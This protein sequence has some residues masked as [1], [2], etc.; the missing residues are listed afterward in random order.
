MDKPS[1]WMYPTFRRLG[2]S[3][4][5]AAA[6]MGMGA[7]LSGDASASTVEISQTVSGSVFGSGNDNWSRSGQITGVSGTVGAGPFRV[8]ADGFGDILAFCVNTAETLSLPGDYTVNASLFGATVKDNLTRLIWTAWDQL[9]TGA[10]DAA[11]RNLGAAFQLAA[12]E[13]IN[14]TESTLNVSKDNGT[15]FVQSGFTTAA[16]NQANAWL[17]ALGDAEDNRLRPVFFEAANPANNQDLMSVVPIPVPAAAW[18]LISA[19]GGMA[20]LRRKT[21]AV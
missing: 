2:H 5:L 3:V 6:A 1:G 14:E 7:V 10:S 4:L 17:G 8:Q 9:G 18:L 21:S 11:N 19:F 20:L 13:I 15:F 16:I 12:W